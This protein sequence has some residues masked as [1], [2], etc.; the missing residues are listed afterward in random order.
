MNTYPSAAAGSN[1]QSAALAP[2]HQVKA[3]KAVRIRELCST[4]EVSCRLRELGLGEGQIVRL[5]A[6]HTNIICQVCQARMALN[7]ALARVILV[8]LLPE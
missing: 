2:L 8:E 1:S 7:A 4:P 5:I 6:S 3:G